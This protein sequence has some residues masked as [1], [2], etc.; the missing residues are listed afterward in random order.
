MMDKISLAGDLGSGKSTV[1]KI[2]IERLGAS[3]YSTGSIVRSI[4]EK[5]G[6]T[7]TELNVY[8]ETHPEID[9]EIDDGLVALADLKVLVD[10]NEKLAA[11]NEKVD[12]AFAELCNYWDKLL[13]IYTVQS[14]DDKLNRMVNIWNQYQCMITF[15]F[16]RSAS[17]SLRSASSSEYWS[18]KV[19]RKRATTTPIFIMSVR[20]MR[21]SPYCE[22]LAI[23]RSL[24]SGSNFTRRIIVGLFLQSR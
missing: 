11:I 13:Q 16:S 19:M 2:L 4:A 6:M 3:Y 1:S 24:P 7:V 21:I 10:C 18:P 23:R 20:S 12:A 8:M 9:H 17:F 5:R 15:C 14:S 22:F